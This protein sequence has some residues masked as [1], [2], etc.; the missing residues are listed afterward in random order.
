MKSRMLSPFSLAKPNGTNGTVRHWT[1]MK[2]YDLRM[3]KVGMA[4]GGG[5]CLT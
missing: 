4:E 2:D 1:R 5:H 3:I